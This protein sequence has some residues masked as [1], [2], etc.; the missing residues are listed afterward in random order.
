MDVQA[1]LSRIGL[2]PSGVAG[3]D[4]KRSSDGLL[5]RQGDRCSTVGHPANDHVERASGA[6][7]RGSGA[8]GGLQLGQTRPQGSMFGFGDCPPLPRVDNPRDR[9]LF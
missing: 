2:L 7:G 5:L 3:D 4:T 8:V 9:R 6:G 1:P